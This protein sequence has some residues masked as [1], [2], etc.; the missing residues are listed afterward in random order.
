MFF[1][2]LYLL[3]A[4]PGLMLALWAQAKVKGAYAKYAQVATLTGYTGE[5]AFRILNRQTA[6]GVNSTHI[7]GELTDH[8]DPRTRTVALSYTSRMNS[9]ASVAIVAHEMGHAM[10]HAERDPL[11]TLRGAI[12]PIV[13][14][15]SG[16]APWLF[17]GGMLLGLGS[18]L[19]S[20]LAWLGVIGFGLAAFF[21]LV[22]LP[23]EFDASRRALAM[24]RSNGLLTETELRGAKQVLDAAAL[25]Y[26]AAAASALLNLLY[27]VLRLTGVRRDE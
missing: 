3:F 18:G 4:I 25:T 19:G 12:V 14:I 24:I 21:S 6:I 2:P 9:V 13:N 27:Y 8:Y 26:V 5:D 17:M 15:G 10:Q 16:L 11:L 20:A 1:D 7:D 22:T 23:V